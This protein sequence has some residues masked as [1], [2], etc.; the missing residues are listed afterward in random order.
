MF[1]ATQLRRGL[2]MVMSCL[3]WFAGTNIVQVHDAKADQITDPCSGFGTN[4]VSLQAELP[5][6]FSSR[7]QNNADCTAWQHFIYANWAADPNNPGY[8]D[9]SVSADKFGNPDS[10]EITVWESFLQASEVFDG[11]VGGQLA[12]SKTAGLPVL[13]QVTKTGTLD[14][15]SIIQASGEWL[16]DQRG[17]LVYYDIRINPDEVDYI[18][19]ANPG[20]QDLTT[21][22]GQL[23]CVQNTGGLL[24]PGGYG[25]DVTCNNT[26]RVFGGDVGAMEIKAAWIQMPEDG[27]LNYR[28]LTSKAILVEAKASAN[29]KVSIKEVTI[30]LVGLHIL[31]RMPGANQLIWS[32]FEQVDN[33]PDNGTD[34]VNLPPNANR[35]PRSGFTFYNPNCSADKDIYYQCKP[36]FTPNDQPQIPCV[37]VNPRDPADCIP[38]SAPMQVTRLV[39]VNSDANAVNQYV[40]SLLPEDSVFNY[41][42]LIDVQW[43]N[44][45]QPV[46]A[47][48]TTPL[49]NGDIT[50]RDSTR[51]V[52]NTT[53][54]TFV[55]DSKGCMDC[56]QYASIAN[57]TQTAVVA[58]SREANV[59]GIKAPRTLLPLTSLTKN[60]S[61]PF[62]SYYSFIFAAKTSK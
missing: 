8:P 60:N 18:L 39:P 55:Q 20:G 12:K 59:L 37:T 47:G 50:P 10:S 46:Q 28:Y 43:P 38:Y 13:D 58:I 32:T 53:L 27:S 6:Q 4:N 33:S 54:E 45:P 49:T 14:L 35:Q 19:N 51:I 3:L 25:Q 30:G 41:Y 23:S 40:W 5:Q 1:I 62:G 9:M 56:H 52:A 16:T 24:L 26:K 57:K 29:S 17:N 42:R 22:A 44:N 11:K 34:T 2:A 48:A 36:N 7:T 21:A 31:R 15:S 61:A